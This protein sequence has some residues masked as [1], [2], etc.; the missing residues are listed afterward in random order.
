MC[1][2]EG[3]YKKI[4]MEGLVI[5]ELTTC[6]DLDDCICGGYVQWMYHSSLCIH[7]D[8]NL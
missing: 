7:I 2:Y 5:D 6:E 4:N 8:V 1:E 3:K